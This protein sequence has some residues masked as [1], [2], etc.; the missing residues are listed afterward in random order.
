MSEQKKKELN[1]I[2]VL[3]KALDSKTRLHLGQLGYAMEDTIKNEYF[4]DENRADRLRIAV[5]KSEKSINQESFGHEQV[6]RGIF[7]PDIQGSVGF[8]SYLIEKLITEDSTF[9]NAKFVGEKG[10]EIDK[11]SVR[12]LIERLQ[13]LL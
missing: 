12:T 3:V 10:Y 5:E 2:D 13:K 4:I 1:I 7:H 11:E 6:S 8:Q 9:G